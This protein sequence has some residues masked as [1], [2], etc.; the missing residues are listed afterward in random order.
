[1]SQSSPP[2]SKRDKASSLCEGNVLTSRITDAINA[3]VVIELMRIPRK[4]LTERFPN[5]WLTTV[6]TS[7]TKITLGNSQT[8]PIT[9]ELGRAR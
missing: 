7:K 5:R 2:E 3:R 6:G 9:S 1:V 4:R 8:G